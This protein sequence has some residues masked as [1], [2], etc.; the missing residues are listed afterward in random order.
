MPFSKCARDGHARRDH[1]I[2][3]LLNPFAALLPLK[4]FLCDH[5]CVVQISLN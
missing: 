3:V 4:G 5:V 1:Y 2:L